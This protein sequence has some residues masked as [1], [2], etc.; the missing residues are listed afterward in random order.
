MTTGLC[1]FG[2]VCGKKHCENNALTLHVFLNLEVTAVRIR[3]I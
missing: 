1:S 2:S 3:H